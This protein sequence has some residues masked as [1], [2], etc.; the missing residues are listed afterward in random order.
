MTI[1]N[2]FLIEQ[3]L[4]DGSTSMTCEWKPNGVVRETETIGM[5][6]SETLMAMARMRVGVERVTVFN[7]DAILRAAAQERASIVEDLARRVATKVQHAHWRWS[8]RVRPEDVARFGTKGSSVEAPAWSK[9]TT[10]CLLWTSGKSVGG[11]KGSAQEPYGSFWVAGS[12]V[13]AHVFAG[14]VLG[15]ATRIP[16]LPGMHLDHLCN[17]TLCVEHTHLESVT[18]TENEARKLKRLNGEYDE[19]G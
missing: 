15:T 4:P 16:H 19:Q 1:P 14:V 9:L 5:P 13:R 11:N 12:T 17:R 3:T 10:P 18:Q 2:F 6:T 8:A 7:Q